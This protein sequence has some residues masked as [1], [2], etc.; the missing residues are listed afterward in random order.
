ML[1]FWIIIFAMVAG[2]L[3]MILPPL[4]KP[5]EALAKNK[6]EEKRAIYQQLFDEIRQ[7]KASGMLDDAQYEAAKIELERRMLDELDIK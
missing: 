2:T 1:L 4:L 6:L 7:D 3:A 5:S